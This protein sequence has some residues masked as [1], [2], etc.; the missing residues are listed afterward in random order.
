MDDGLTVIHALGRRLFESFGHRSMWCTATGGTEIHYH[1]SGESATDT[2]PPIILVHGMHT[3]AL[4]WLVF[5]PLLALTL[6]RRVITIDLPDFD[7]GFSYNRASPSAGAP[8]SSSSSSSGS[9]SPPPASARRD[10][11]GWAAASAR[12]EASSTLEG[13]V[14]AVQHVIH[15]LGHPQVRERGRSRDR[16]RDREREIERE[17]ERELERGAV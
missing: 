9:A 11:G 13:H 16:E 8:S 2:G 17:R 10:Y 3:T 1:D 6:R 5:S 12:A 15:E 7:Y 14:E 4:C